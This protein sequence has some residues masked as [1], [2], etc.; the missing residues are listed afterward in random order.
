MSKS[1]FPISQVVTSSMVL[2][3]ALHYFGSCFNSKP[4]G[5]AEGQFLCEQHCQCL[6]VS[7]RSPDP[8]KT[9][10]YHSHKDYASVQTKVI[11]FYPT[12]CHGVGVGK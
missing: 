5:K 2:M 3:K 8:P 9:L 6:S 11:M 12:L 7:A 10:G 4:F 1:V